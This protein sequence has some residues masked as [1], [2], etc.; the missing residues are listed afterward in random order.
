[1]KNSKRSVKNK[2]D[3]I[4]KPMHILAFRLPSAS[5]LHVIR[6]L[7]ERMKFSDQD[8]PIEYIE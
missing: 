1:M 6:I 8:F 2:A 4:V 7:H 5:E 3:R